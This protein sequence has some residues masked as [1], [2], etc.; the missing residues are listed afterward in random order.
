MP[1]SPSEAEDKEAIWNTA[2]KKVIYM[3]SGLS[4]ELKMISNQKSWKLEGW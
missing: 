4:I 2:H 1:H 3:Y